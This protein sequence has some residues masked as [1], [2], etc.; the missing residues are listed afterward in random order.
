MAQPLQPVTGDTGDIIELAYEANRAGAEVFFNYFDELWSYVH[1]TD[2]GGQ[3]YTVV[4]DDEQRTE[5]AVFPGHLQ[6][7]SLTEGYIVHLEARD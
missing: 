1:V 3:G 4:R 5:V 7:D 6:S 2:D